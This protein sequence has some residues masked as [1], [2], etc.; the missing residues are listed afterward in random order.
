MQHKISHFEDLF[1]SQSLGSVTQRTKSNTTKANN[2]D[3]KAKY[4]KSKP[5]S[6]K[7]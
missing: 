3:K 7:T 6:N 4:T 2:R 1:P 5:K